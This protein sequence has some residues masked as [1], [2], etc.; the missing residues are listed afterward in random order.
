MKFT[1]HEFEI[2]M[3]DRGDGVNWTLKRSWFGN[4]CLLLYLAAAVILYW[5]N[6]NS[7][8]LFIWASTTM[9]LYYIR[10]YMQ[11]LWYATVFT[12][13]NCKNMTITSLK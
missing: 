3:K 2:K 7:L 5:I 10:I 12:I 8:Y 6:D 1:T 11:S 4:I 13:L 9:I